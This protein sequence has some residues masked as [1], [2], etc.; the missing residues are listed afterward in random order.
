MILPQCTH[1]H[2]KHAI[3]LR[4]LSVDNSIEKFISTSRNFSNT[5]KYLLFNAI[6]YI[7]CVELKKMENKETLNL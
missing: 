3:S 6:A 4:L 7:V 1:I 2:P 5:F